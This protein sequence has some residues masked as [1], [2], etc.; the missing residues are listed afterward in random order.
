MR[1]FT[2]LHQTA[3]RQYS[4]GSCRKALTGVIQVEAAR[5]RNDETTWL[6]GQLDSRDR[7]GGYD[8]P[9]RHSDLQGERT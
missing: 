4:G 1:V 9:A 7:K 8:D 2:L 3:I 5:Y 6:A